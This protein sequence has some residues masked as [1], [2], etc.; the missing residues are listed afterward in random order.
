M[1][2]KKN[3]QLGHLPQRVTDTK[4]VWHKLLWSFLHF[5]H[6]G[7]GEQKEG[8]GACALT[9]LGQGGLVGCREKKGLEEKLGLWSGERD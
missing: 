8:F 3:K 9:E 2:S 7:S 1:Q 4:S 5:L 6:F